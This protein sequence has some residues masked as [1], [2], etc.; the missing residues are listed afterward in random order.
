[1]APQALRGGHP[2]GLQGA[3][4]PLRK[5]FPTKL[6][7]IA[8]QLQLRIIGMRDGLDHVD[9]LQKRIVE[10]LFDVQHGRDRQHA[11]QRI[12]PV[13]R[14]LSRKTASSVAVRSSR[15]SARSFCVL[16]RESSFSPGRAITPSSASQNLSV[17]HMT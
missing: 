11:S 1:M 17:M 2:S 15:F 6:Q 7:R 14:G 5:S 4:Y 10:S 13:L 16:K 3:A 8:Q 12:Q 9:L